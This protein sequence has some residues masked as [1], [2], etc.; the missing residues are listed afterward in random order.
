MPKPLALA[1]P[2][3]C[4]AGRVAIEER[5]LNG[6]FVLPASVPTC[7][8]RLEG[9]KPVRG[10]DA[11]ESD[12]PRLGMRPVT[13]AAACAVA[14]RIGSG[15]TTGRAPSASDD[16]AYCNVTIAS[17]TASGDSRSGVVL[18]AAITPTNALP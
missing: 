7:Q 12:S 4:A 13:S 17:P 9:G 1:Q 5:G 10:N 18:L 8:P 6:R 14:D 15:R 11:A 2:T 3:V 16:G